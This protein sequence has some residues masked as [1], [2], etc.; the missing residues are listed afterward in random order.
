MTTQRIMNSPFTKTALLFF[1]TLFVIIVSMVFVVGHHDDLDNRIQFDLTNHLGHEVSERHFAG[2]YQLVF[3]GFTSCQMVCPTQMHKLTRLMSEL[4]RQGQG[5]EIN[6]IFITVD[7][8][9]DTPE[10]ISSYL[11]HFH[12]RIV[13]LTGSREQLT[14]AADAFKTLMADAPV[15][16]EEGYQIQHSSVMYVVDPFSRVV[17]YISFNDDAEH[18]A[19]KIQSYL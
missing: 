3:F 18:M 10:K 2:R 14:A 13:G 17:D 15:N 1:T 16:P 5:N 12:N 8:E 4:D 11:D 19:N 6:P 7:P 9:R